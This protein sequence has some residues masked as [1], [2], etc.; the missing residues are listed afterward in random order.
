[1]N[2]VDLPNIGFLLEKLNP[3][4][5]QRL[6]KEVAVFIE[7]YKKSDEDSNHDLLRQFHKRKAGYS[8]QYTLSDSLVQD[9]KKEV[10]KLIEKLEYNFHYFEKIFNFTVNVE[11]CEMRLE[12]ERIWVNFQS[13][14]EFLPLHNHTGVYSFVIWVHIPFNMADEKDT[15][16]NQDLIKSRQGNFEFIYTDALGKISNHTIPVD[17]SFEGFI[18]VFP[19]DLY[20]QVYPFYSVDGVRVSVAGN[21]RVEIEKKHEN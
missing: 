18:A 16:I 7:D 4:L 20:H 3:F 19:S 15:I 17:Q 14:G 9:I 10:I 6:K 12:L 8:S 1:M 5:F 11:N 13:T 2:L 21:F